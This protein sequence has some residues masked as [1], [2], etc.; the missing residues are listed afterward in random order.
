METICVKCKLLFSWEN[1]YNVTKLLSAE[2]AQR[3]V[4]VKLPKREHFDLDL[5]TQAK[6]PKY[7]G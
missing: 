3:V 1:K 2:L 7:L 4:T 6:L 5:F